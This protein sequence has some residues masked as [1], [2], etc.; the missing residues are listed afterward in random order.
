M[1][2]FVFVTHAAVDGLLRRDLAVRPGHDGEADG[3][4]PATGHEPVR[5]RGRVGAHHHRPGHQLGAVAGPVP[6]GQFRGELRDGIVEHT[7]VIGDGVGPRV[8]G[9]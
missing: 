2:G 1:T 6:G 3:A 7:E 4:R 5:G 8:A 9:P